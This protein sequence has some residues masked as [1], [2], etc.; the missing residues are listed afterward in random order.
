MPF[1]DVVLTL[2]LVNYVTNSS[3]TSGIKL[4][5]EYYLESYFIHFIYPLQIMDLTPFMNNPMLKSQA[6]ILA[7]QNTINFTT[8][9][10]VNISN[11]QLIIII[12]MVVMLS[13]DDKFPSPGSKFI[14]PLRIAP[15]KWS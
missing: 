3:Y 5:A 12:V 14:S 6:N 4:N 10:Q 13:I 11:F 8:S 1:A 15:A 2:L 7:L 9:H